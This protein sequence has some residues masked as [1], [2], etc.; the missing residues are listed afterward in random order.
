[1]IIRNVINILV[2][3]ASTSMALSMAA[4]GAPVLPYLDYVFALARALLAPYISNLGAELR[5]LRFQ[6]DPYLYFLFLFSVADSD[7]ERF[8]MDRAFWFRCRI[9]DSLTLMG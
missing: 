4:R 1:M 3:Y 7:R 9:L 8:F 5:L 6:A 2:Y